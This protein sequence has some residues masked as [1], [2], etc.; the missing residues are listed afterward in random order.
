MGLSI[1]RNLVEQNEGRMWG[2]SEPG[3]TEIHFTLPVASKG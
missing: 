1:C 2:T 3:R